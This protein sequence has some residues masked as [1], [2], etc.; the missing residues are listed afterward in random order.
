VS[1]WP[2]SGLL[3]WLSISVMITPESFKRARAQPDLRAVRFLAIS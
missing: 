2:L 1:P 3:S